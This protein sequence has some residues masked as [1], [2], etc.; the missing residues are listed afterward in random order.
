MATQAIPNQTVSLQDAELTPF[1]R[2][3]GLP[4]FIQP[5]NPRLTYDYAYF[6]DWYWDHA[7]AIDQLLSE[8]GALVFRG[9]AMRNTEEFDG[10]VANYDSMASGYS[11]GATPRG[12]LGENVFEATSTPAR[13]QIALHQEMA[14]LPIY[15][16]R[17]IFFCRMP[18]IN[19]GETMLGDMRRLTAALDQ[20]F[21][22]QVERLGVLY[23]RNLRDKNISTGNPLLDPIHKSWQDAF[24]T[25]DQDE[26]VK[27]AKAVGLGA[28]WLDDGSLCVTYLG[29]GLIEHPRTGERLWFNQLQTLNLGP[30]N[31]EKYDM[32]ER[33]YGAT[34]RFPFAA[35]LGDGT[36]LTSGQAQ[37]LADT[38]DRIAVEFPWSGGDILLI[39]NYRVAHGRNTFT[40][41][42]DVQVALLG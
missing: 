41:L 18:C 6:R 21:V 5:A 39:D 10:L 28:E 19:G 14:Y 33:Q 31:T 23:T 3:D 2:G 20:K 26:A 40:G 36:P 34:G 17:L 42:R 15:P 9:F 30:H 13:V 1:E 11:G 22:G 8:V 4:L 7:P 37:A 38:G 27:E 25:E 24:L 32:Y 12:Q 16:Q 29:P 35:T